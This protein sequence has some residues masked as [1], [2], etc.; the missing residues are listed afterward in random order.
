M[1]DVRLKL[2]PPWVTY[3]NKLQALFD[4]D[5]LIAF[6]INYGA[7]EGPEVVLSTTNG[8]KAAALLKLLPTEKQFGNVTLKIIVDSPTVSNLAFVTPK[9]L[10]DIAFDKN[11]AYAGA[12]SP[13]EE[14]YWFFNITY[15]ISIIFNICEI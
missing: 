8:D 2:S 9:Q 10:F 13:T 11:P 6:N 14:G 1:N 12:I 4:G 5:P 3:V 15:I 7:A